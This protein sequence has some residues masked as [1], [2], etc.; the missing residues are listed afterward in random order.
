MEKEVL[1]KEVE[2]ISE[3]IFS[4]LE[5]KK[6]PKQVAEMALLSSWGTLCIDQGHTPKEIEALL[7]NY[8]KTYKTSW[9]EYHEPSVK[10]GS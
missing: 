7:F 3:Q 8:I 5:K 6:C 1:Y 2:K 10:K 9:K 4:L